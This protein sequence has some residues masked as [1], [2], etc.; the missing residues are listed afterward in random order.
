M[1]SVP[2]RPTLGQFLDIKAN[3]VNTNFRDRGFSAPDAIRWD[4]LAT[5]APDGPLPDPQN[6]KRRRHAT[7]AFTHS[8]TLAEAAEIDRPGPVPAPPER[9]DA[10]PAAGCW[11][12]VFGGAEAVPLDAALARLFPDDCERSEQLR[13]NFWHIAAPGCDPLAAMAGTITATG[14]EKY[15]RRCGSVA[16]FL[17]EITPA[18]DGS[19][20]SFYY[21]V[22]LGA[23]R[24]ALAAAWE[25]ASAESWALIEG[26]GEREFRLLTKRSA[27]D[28]GRD[29]C[30]TI[31][32]NPGALRRFEFNGDDGKPRAAGSLAEILESFAL[33]KFAGLRLGDWQV[34]RQRPWWG[35]IDLDEFVPWME[36]E[37]FMDTLNT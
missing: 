29:H 24:R 34:I 17:E 16:E 25:D 5:I 26:E 27:D 4:T 1:I 9:P 10:R 2:L 19:A 15:F 31:T 35:E 21:G 7:A 32:V 22:C 30:R 33:Q 36:P 11:S 18:G 14:F 20:P 23:D 37:E 12:E 13:T 8:T 6:W 3:S 28:G